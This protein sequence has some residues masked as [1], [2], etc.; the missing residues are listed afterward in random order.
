MNLRL[1]RQ[2]MPI[3]L[4]EARE[5]GNPTLRGQKSLRMIVTGAAM[6]T[7]GSGNT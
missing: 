2:A 3:P 7:E 1:T 6:V 4:T 5:Q